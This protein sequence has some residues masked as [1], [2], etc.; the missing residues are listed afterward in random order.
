VKK[1]NN[2]ILQNIKKV[3][4]YRN[5]PIDHQNYL[6][7]IRKEYNFIPKTIYDIGACVLHWTQSAEQIWP[8]S[9]IILFDATDAFESLYLETKL[10][11]Y[12]GALSNESDKTI[13]FYQNNENFAGNSYYRENPKYS[14]AAEYLFNE[15]SIV[16]LTTKTLDDVVADKFLNPPQLIKI[17]VQG[18]ELDVL[19]GSDRSLTTCEHLI[20]ELRNIE[21]NIG[22]PD[23]ETII[24]YLKTKEFKNLGLFSDN[25]PDGD[26]HFIKE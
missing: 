20:V 4:N 19:M 14:S 24:D 13:K 26:Y 10:N 23:K 18:A 17:D 25:G 6:I 3:S 11:Y 22:S 9:E 16:E 5:M 7:K 12:I 21:Y 1:Y 8:E 2:N 15:S